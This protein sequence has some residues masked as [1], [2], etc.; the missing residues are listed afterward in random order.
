MSK[1]F[2]Y[3]ISAIAVLTLLLGS[4]AMAPAGKAQPAP[5]RLQSGTII[6]AKSNLAANGGKYFIVQFQGPIEQAW[7]DAI[8]TRG[9]EILD[10]IPDFAFK[11][12]MSPGVAK[13]V[14]SESFVSVVMP[15]EG[16][17]KFR[18]GLM[19][20]SETRVYVI[21]FER[22]SD[23]TS[24]RGLIQKAGVQVLDINGDTAFVAA[25]SALLDAIANVEDVASISNFY[26]N[27]TFSAP[28]V[29]NGPPS[30]DASRD[31]IGATVANS[32]G[33]DGSTQTVA[34]ADTGL[35]GGTT[36]TAHRDIPSSRITAIFNWPGAAGSC[37]KTV[38][39]DGSIDVDSG[40]G[41][42]TSG[43]VL[44]GGAPNGIGSG[45][46]PA[47]HLVFQSTENYA[48]IT[49]LCKT[50]YGYTNGYYLLGLPSD[51]K[52]LY[53]Q[54]YDAGA[55]I[56][57]NSWGAAVAGDYN[58]DGV[59]TD[60]FVWNHR[61]MVITFSAGN[62]GIDA[63]SD[64]VIDNDSMGSP[65]TSK[66]VITVGAS[67]NQRTDNYPCDSGLSYT[68]CASQG[69][70]NVI[71]TYGTSWPSD[72]PAN[73]IFS[74]PAAGNAN[75]MAAF[76]SRGPTDDG[77]IKPDVVAPGTW[78]LS[79]YSDLYQQ[80]YDASA[81]PKN[82]A[83]QYDGWGFPYDAYYKY[84]GGTSMSNPLTAGGA[85][86]VKDYFNK[87]Y[88]INASAALVKA[89][90]INSAVDIL[91]ENND[92]ANDN[93]F[94]IPNNIE[95]WGRVNLDAATDGTIQYVDEGTGLS[96][97]GNASYQVTTTGGPLKVTVVWTDYPSTDTATVNLVNDLDLTVSGPSGTF[98]GNV[99]SGGWSATGGSADRRNNVE[100]VY[101]QSPAAGTYT[102]TINGYNIP[103]G[104][105]KFALAVKGGT[106]GTG[107][108]PTP[109]PTNTPTFTPTA[110]FTPTITNTPGSSNSTG[111]LV[112]SANT[113]VTSSAGDNNG[114]Q[115]NPANAYN[116][117]S[118]FAVDTNSGTNTNTSCTNTG[119][120]KHNF[121]NYNINL[122]GTAVVQG[123]QVRLDARAD[124][125]TGAPKICVQLS[126]D[127]GT[128]WTTAKQTSTLTTSEAT[129]VLGGTADTWGRTWAVGN[130]SN[131][132]FRIRV[133]DVASN[134]QRD[135]SLDYIAVN[136]TYQP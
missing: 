133:I 104:P 47:A 6:P 45:T 14:A 105:Q 42:H 74:D 85:A 5:L 111:Y 70:A 11:V 1:A 67:E 135:F 75:Q 9:A 102:V 4:L 131:A 81:N 55:R 38:T 96:T 24:A 49:A 15:F 125:T 30:N 126:W 68:T 58:T 130:F 112:P 2:R 100:N 53:Q 29:P 59:N 106:L 117:N 113:A 93:D 134:Q 71:A 87:A 25:N 51:L 60:N 114:Y 94:P 40:H 73:P 48:T 136:V 32:R 12:R 90:L 99:F 57:S 39:N 41:T 76:S 46:A 103:S 33:Y 65:G 43:S 13:Q 62:E 18:A 107:P 21:R 54:A 27:E 128:T 52:T 84:M 17:F 123:I 63:N 119:K 19:R 127:G 77:R 31:I 8:T 91:D 44:S 97:G 56:H 129:Y 109:I 115:T 88:G 36:T 26:L 82:G 98:K 124:S 79:T 110:T 72:Y 34:I 7:K 3:L 20:D 132:N 108:T 121:Y 50:L 95:G 92:G 89:T 35:G 120:D 10:Y 66:N 122:P 101:I 80:G 64:G 83:Y 118:V 86:V 116:D 61:D 78:I 28:A 37:F 16:K 69:G 23:F 22:G